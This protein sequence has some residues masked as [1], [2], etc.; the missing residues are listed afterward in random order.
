MELKRIKLI[1]FLLGL[2]LLFLSLDMA[3]RF[4][5]PKDVVAQQQNKFEYKA[6]PDFNSLQNRSVEN[7][8]AVLNQLGEQGW[9]LSGYAD[10]GEDKLLVFRRSK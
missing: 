8:N 10:N 9:I 5:N 7:V 1:N 3:I 2:I 6:I 4:I